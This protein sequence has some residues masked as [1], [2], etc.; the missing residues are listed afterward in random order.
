MLLYSTY[1]QIQRQN[2][3]RFDEQ[4]CFAAVIRFTDNNRKT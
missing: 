4:V 2:A 1:Q 3:M